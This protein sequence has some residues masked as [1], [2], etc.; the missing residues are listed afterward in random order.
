M[1]LVYWAL[2]EGH[3]ACLVVSQCAGHPWIEHVGIV[4][5]DHRFSEVVQSFASSSDWHHYSFAAPVCYKACLRMS[6][7]PRTTAEHCAVAQA[8]Q[9]GAKLR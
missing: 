1:E 8:M 7:N 6:N 2:V 9:H 4:F 3:Q 5:E